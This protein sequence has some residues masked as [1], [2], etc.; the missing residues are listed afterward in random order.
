M[1]KLSILKNNKGMAVLELVPTLFVYMLLINFSLGF[2]GIVHSGILHSIAARNYTFETFAHRTNLVYHIRP[3]DPSPAALAK[4]N[5]EAK[6]Y[7]YSGIVSEND[8]TETKWIATDRPIA[9]T[10]QF[11]GTD[12]DGVDLGGRN[13]GNV[14]GESAAHNTGVRNLNEA[15]RNETIAVKSIWIKTIYGICMN[16]KC[17]DP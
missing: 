11:G 15:V 12:N 8:K 13:P 3:K 14:T 5:F 10:S 7:R 9:F 4:N 16:S 6:G 17:G 2:F 1:L